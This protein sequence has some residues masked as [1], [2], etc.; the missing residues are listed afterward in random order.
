VPFRGARHG[1]PSHPLLIGRP[2]VALDLAQ[3]GV[4]AECRRI[5]LAEHLASARPRNSF[6][7]VGFFFNL[8]DERDTCTF[9]LLTAKRGHIS[10]SSQTL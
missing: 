6:V 1:I 9:E 8:S 7:A 5:S 10:N 3:A 4:P 2:G